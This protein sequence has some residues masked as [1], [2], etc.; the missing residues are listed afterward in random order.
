MAAAPGESAGS[1]LVRCGARSWRFDPGATVLV[2]RG[3]DCDVVVN[4]PRLSREHLR[5]EHDGGWTLCDPGTVNG[6]WVG[7][8]RLGSRRIDGPLTVS[9]GDP[10]SGSSLELDLADPPAGRPAHLLDTVSLGRAV[11]ND[12]VLNDV[13]VSRHHARIER[14]AAGR[15]VIDL[16]S[17]NRTLVNGTAAAPAISLAD[18]DRLTVGNTEFVLDGDDLKP[19][20]V[21]R[22]RLVASEVCYELPGGRRVLTGVSLDA[23]PGDLIAI[24]GPSGVGKSTLLR[25]LIGELDPASG[26]VSY[27]GYDV[28]RQ[29]DAVRSRI[30]LVP[31]DDVVHARLTAR[32]ALTFAARLRLADDT[33]AGDRR[34]RVTQVL[35]ELGLR[36][37]ADV[38]IDRL[39]GGQRKRVN[40]ALELLTSPS[41]LILDEPT[42]GLDPALDRQIMA[43]LREIADAG[44][45]VVVV[46]HNVSNLE[47][48]NN[49]LLLAPGGLPVYFG[50]PSGLL[51][52]FGGMD[53]AEV[54]ARV[55][56]DPGA[57]H[58]AS[59]SAAGPPP[60]R[61]AGRPPADGATAAPAA[62][63]APWRIRARQART[64]AARHARL[65][66]ADRWYALFLLLLP[67]VLAG[68]ALTVPGRA[69]LG[70]PAATEPTEPSQL[71]VLLFVGAAFMG[72]AAAA[73]EIIGERAIFLRERTA[74][75]HPAAYALAKLGVYTVICAGQAA[76]LVGGA[77]SV[78]AAP[79][80][81]VLLE[82][83]TAEIAV[84][85]WGTALAS[86]LLSLLCS[87]LVR[88]SEQV[89]PVLVVTVMAQLVL[90]GG[91]IPV[92]GRPGLSILAWLAPTRWGYAAGSA[93][94][95]L[96]R[97]V[98]GTPADRLWAHTPGIWLISIGA[99]LAWTAT[100]TLLV[101]V[102]TARL[103]R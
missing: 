5:I 57:A 25:A 59:A 96:R 88:S 37:R 68:L 32:Q 95:D 3:A 52:R 38:R 58:Q 82:S 63:P 14:T 87:A 84:A 46:T 77:L 101:T 24:I 81:G 34:L 17:R 90:C 4:D 65:I 11:D 45:T 72:G 99:L 10:T 79:V 80:G 1:L 91:M 33:T 94:I 51:H 47:R 15:R 42:S 64:L 53:W 55:I 100:Y 89:M 74:G 44:R 43:R 66:L 18:G 48:C 27:D 12:I 29:F 35:D 73:R 41:L 92:T 20:T 76:L 36:D 16:G 2:G 61:P 102:R 40:I 67:G 78:K 13:L 103:R 69:G 56:D 28:H 75:L 62:R 9:L 49:L 30:G 98:P 83:A 70:T 60:A 71:L 86:C 39:S 6:T 19:A 97:L 31:Q 23:G 7:G 22:A 85:I 93:T 50:R 21:E 26:F 54:Y 8:L